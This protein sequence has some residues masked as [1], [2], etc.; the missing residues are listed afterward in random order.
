MPANCRIHALKKCRG[1]KAIQLPAL[2]KSVLAWLIRWYLYIAS[3]FK[4]HLNS[5]EEMCSA[6]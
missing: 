6:Y 3:H 1:K 4:Q 2:Y 5:M